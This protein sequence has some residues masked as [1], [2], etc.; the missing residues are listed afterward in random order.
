LA[1][2]FLA[3]LAAMVLSK[4]GRQPVQHGTHVSFALPVRACEA[5][6]PSLRSAPDL[7]KALAETPAYA[8]PL[9]QYP[10]AEIQR[11]S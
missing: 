10:N 2:G 11:V 8:A 4:S 9:D 7:R 5:C 1:A 6:D 3:G